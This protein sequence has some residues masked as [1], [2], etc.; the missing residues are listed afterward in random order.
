MSAIFP[1]GVEDA[2]L[3]D[4]IRGAIRA[5]VRAGWQ[6][7]LNQLAHSSLADGR[8]DTLTERQIA[9]MVTHINA[10]TRDSLATT[11]RLGLASGK[12]TADIAADIQ[13]SVAFGSS[14]ALAIS[15]TETTRAVNG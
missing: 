7:G 1:A 10:T 14:R 15:R 11:V 3:A 9:D 13:A 4:A 6:A 2:A 8:I 5:A 12:S